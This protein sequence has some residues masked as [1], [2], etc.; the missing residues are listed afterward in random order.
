[1]NTTIYLIRHSIPFK[2]HRGIELIDDDIL[3]WNMKS[4]LSIEG[5][6]ISKEYFKKKEFRNIDVVWAS[7][8]VRAMTTAKYLAYHNHLKVNV[9]SI[10]N[11]RIHGI[12]NWDELPSDFEKRQLEDET[13]KIG[14][15]E[16]RK[17]VK[18][19]MLQGANKLLEEYKGKTLLL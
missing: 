18:E 6:E 12:N 11:E 14:N 10:F 2:E 15:G 16:S 5:E 9:A 4:P 3:S 19:R 17:E 7:S 1:M 13:Y 8:Y